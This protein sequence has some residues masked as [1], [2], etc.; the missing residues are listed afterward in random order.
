MNAVSHSFDPN[1]VNVGPRGCSTT[2]WNSWHSVQPA[3]A[4]DTSAVPSMISAW[5]ASSASA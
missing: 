1:P 4:D 5:S 3:D 2:P